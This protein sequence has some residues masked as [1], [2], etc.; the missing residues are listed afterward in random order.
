MKT[1]IK[2]IA[3]AVAFSAVF[4]F[5][6]FADDKEAK[7]AGFGTGI[8]ASKSGKIH[9]NVDKYGSENTAIVVT[10][11][12]GQLMYREVMGKGVS[13]SRTA[14]NVSDLPAGNYRIEISSKSGKEV[15]RFNLTDEKAEREISL[16]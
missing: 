6:S 2:S 11:G 12:A 14:L 7:K 16:N 9:I 3:L 13:K 4:A 1:S 5:N 10:N 8:F 15:K